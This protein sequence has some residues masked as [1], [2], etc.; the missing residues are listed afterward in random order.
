MTRHPIT[1]SY[2]NRG[3]DA[4]RFVTISHCLS[5]IFHHPSRNWFTV[6]RHGH[7]AAPSRPRAV[8]LGP[9]PLCRTT[10]FV[11]GFGPRAKFPD[12]SRLAIGPGLRITTRLPSARLPEPGECR[13]RERHRRGRSPSFTN[14]ERSG[15]FKRHPA[16]WMRP[17]R[18][19]CGPS[20]LTRR[21]VAKFA[22][23]VPV[24]DAWVRLCEGGIP[25]LQ[26]AQPG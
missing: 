3:R 15:P 1:Q 23:R 10:T 4:N 19:R 11:I 2:S 9:V 14:G 18:M 8:K 13:C 6:C 21:T 25:R 16:N 7:R 22:G 17:W 26:P 24:P 12:R 5:L 20:F